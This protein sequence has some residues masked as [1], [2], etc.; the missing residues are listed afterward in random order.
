MGKES[1]VRF[2]LTLFN[3][4]LENIMHKRMKKAGGGYGKGNGMM[5]RKPKGMGGRSMYGH[6]GE[7]MKKATPC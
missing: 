6:G 2:P 1:G 3:F 5:Q 7:A 4:N